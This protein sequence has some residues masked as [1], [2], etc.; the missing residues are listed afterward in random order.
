MAE[1]RAV[2]T[3]LVMYHLLECEV[4]GRA[5]LGPLSRHRVVVT[6]QGSVR[7]Y[8]APRPPHYSYLGL[9]Y[10]R[11][12]THYDRFKAP[13]PPP[14]WSGIFEAIHRVK[15]P[16]P[17]GS[18]DENC[19]VVNVFTPE[20]AETAPVIV[21]IHDGGFQSGWG[22]FTA[23]TRFLEQGFV[24]IS[25]NY[26]I[27]ALGFL[28]LGIED[29]PGNAGIKDQ[30]AA[31]YWIHRNVEKFGGDSSDI[32][33]YG[34]GS[35]AVSIEII[36]MSGLTENLFQKVILESGSILSPSS[37]TRDPVL[38]AFDFAKSTGYKGDSNPQPLREYYYDVPVKILTNTS[39]I[40]RPCIE[41][42]VAEYHNLLERDPRDV[43]R[44]GKY[45]HVP[46]MIVY[47]QAEEVDIILHDP[48]TFQSIIDNME[49]L[50]PANLIF[51]SSEVKD[52]IIKLIKKFYFD[53]IDTASGITHSLADY[54]N[55][56]FLE[57]P[58]AK[59][60]T[61]Y[62]NRNTY[63]VYL[64][65]F[66]DLHTRLKDHRYVGTNKY[67]DILRYITSDRLED[68]EDLQAQKL[69]MLWTNFI[70]VGDPTPLTSPLLPVIWQPVQVH[71]IH[72]QIAVQKIPCLQF[73]ETFTNILLSGKH[74]KFWDS[75]YDK[76]YRTTTE[77]CN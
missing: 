63:P 3:V 31:L 38:L 36:L 49:D 35:G 11:P 40:F 48:E 21:H 43:L 71:E 18:G 9:P 58:V 24:F 67:N 12:P 72:G 37:L 41:R 46:L 22:T 47:T 34:T 57:Y 66:A 50:L 52:K 6:T 61:Y 28:S 55:D 77:K 15:C 54:I 13:E 7:G 70:N 23:P 39:R 25:L 17:D 42:T 56:V 20:D 2:T 74:L 26:R 65:K 59:S 32:T 27:G 68:S 45:Q 4:T 8:F 29:V 5:P 60:V 10:A 75:I 64:M 30:V 1:Y 76:F 69:V 44:E 62:A 51:D 33:V 19:L 16:Q 73:D 53:D 14:R